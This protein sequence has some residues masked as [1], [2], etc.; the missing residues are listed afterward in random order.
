[1][2][3]ET[4]LDES[5]FVPVKV[6]FFAINS[7]EN[8]ELE[9]RFD[10]QEGCTPSQVKISAYG[11][12]NV[13]QSAPADISF[14]KLTV[15]H[16]RLMELFPTTIKKE[17][18]PSLPRSP[19][20][21]WRYIGWSKISIPEGLN[22]NLAKYFENISR[23]CG[24]QIV[25]GLFMEDGLPSEVDYEEKWSEMHRKHYSDKKDKALKEYE[26]ILASKSDRIFVSIEQLHDYYVE[27]DE[28]EF[29]LKKAENL[30]YIYQS[31][32]FEDLCEIALSRRNEAAQ[33]VSLNRD[34]QVQLT[35]AR[36][37]KLYH[38][39]YMEAKE[40]VDELLLER[41]QREAERAELKLRR[42]EEDRDNLGE[43]FDKKAW[44]RLE[45]I[46]DEENRS[47]VRYL[48]GKLEF[49]A[50]QR[51]LALVAMAKIEEGPNMETEILEC[52]DRVYNIHIKYLDVQLRLFKEEEVKLQF[53]LQYLD[54]L[55]KKKTFEEKI[56]KLRRR[57]AKYRSIKVC[58]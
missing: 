2:E 38:E 28:A 9:C 10:V 30:Y 6:D 49:L 32:P 29:F 34:E 17:D 13:F 16:Q 40:K 14:D 27:E 41:Y 53:Q 47:I 35:T 54:D 57:S 55:Q 15:L 12:S 52:E 33:R 46:K 22:L 4:S 26:D 8:G 39:E 56:L 42:M 37:E 51:E 36:E 24:L 1:M 31:K 50:G 5:E 3:R 18:L 48:E 44:G 19:S 21:I 23:I 43:H 11:V 45:A 20:G 58:L 25:L 7:S